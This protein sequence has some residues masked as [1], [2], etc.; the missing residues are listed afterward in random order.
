VSTLVDS[1]VLL[2][3]LAPS[4]WRQWSEEHLATAVDAGEVAINQVIYAEIAVGFSTRER[5]ERALQGV[6][7]RRLSLPWASAWLVSD[8][9]ARY[10]RAGGPRTRPLPDFFIGAHAQAAELALLTRDPARVSTYFP[11]VTLIAPD[12]ADAPATDKN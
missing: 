12:S 8:A 5:L 11:T 1:S 6:G 9:F 7:I 3:I 2:D 4:P 10:R